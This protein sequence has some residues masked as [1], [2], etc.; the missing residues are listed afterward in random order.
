MADIYLEAHCIITMQV[1]QGDN[2]SCLPIPS[3]T[4][5]DDQCLNII[6]LIHGSPPSS[7]AKV[8][9]R[10]PPFTHG[11]LRQ[12][13]KISANMRLA[14]TASNIKLLWEL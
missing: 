14:S 9:I 10:F 2:I 6:L 5:I 1:H 7:L 4:S 11:G 13:C 8:P 3:N 12:V